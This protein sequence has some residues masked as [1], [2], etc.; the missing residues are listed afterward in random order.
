[1]LLLHCGEFKHATVVLQQL[2]TMHWLQGV[3]PGSSEH[4][5]ASLT[6]LPQR[7]LRHVRPT[8]HCAGVLQLE[9]C[10]RHAPEPHC[11]FSLQSAEQHSSAELHANPSTLHWVAPQV[12][13]LQ[14][15]VQHSKL[16]LQPKPSG[17]HC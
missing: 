8:Q 17:L 4:A 6:G 15:P 1:M 13:S 5:P 7:P 3:P 10:A 2:P 16:W 14:K 12:P 9:P 11:P